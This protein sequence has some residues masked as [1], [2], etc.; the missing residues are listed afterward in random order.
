[1]PVLPTPQ[2]RLTEAKAALHALLTGTSV[3]EVRD[4]DGSAVTYSRA[5]AAGLRAYIQDLQAE[6]AGMSRV[7]GPLKVSF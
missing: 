5:S 6:V 2:E 1:M 4:A 3:V 7:R